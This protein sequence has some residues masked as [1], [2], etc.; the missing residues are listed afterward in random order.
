MDSDYDPVSTA[1]DLWATTGGC[2]GATDE[3][4]SASVVRQVRTGCLAGYGVELYT[5][6]GGGHAWPGGEPGWAEGD[7][8]TTE[9]VATDLIWDFFAAHPKP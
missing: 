1:V 5:V 2:T 6:D 9:V 4:V 8:P 3:Q 7:E